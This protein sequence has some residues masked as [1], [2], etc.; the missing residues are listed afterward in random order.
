MWHNRYK[1]LKLKT[2]IELFVGG[3]VGL[4]TILTLELVGLLLAAF[5]AP[6]WVPSIGS[7]A[8]CTGVL[9]SFCGLFNFFTALQAAGDV[10]PSLV[11][12]GMRS[13]LIGLIYSI[14]IFVVSRIIKIILSP[15]M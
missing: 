3:G 6:R 13:M 12:G 8:I 15:R 7:I 2:M 14:S 9:G 1:S 5:K 11:W 4:M 10:H